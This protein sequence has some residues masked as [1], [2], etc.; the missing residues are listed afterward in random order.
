VF[1][2]VIPDNMKTVVERADAI[3]PKLNDAFREYA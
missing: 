3:N 1:A 2:V